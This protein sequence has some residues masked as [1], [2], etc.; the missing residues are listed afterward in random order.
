MTNSQSKPTAAKVAER[1]ESQ[2]KSHPPPVGFTKLA[3]AA[4]KKESSDYR[5]FQMYLDKKNDKGGKTTQSV[6]I[7]EDGDPETWCDWCRHMED[8]FAFMKVKEDDT[9]KKIQLITS[10]LRGKALDSFRTYQAAQEEANNSRKEPWDED[11]VLDHI[12]NDMALEIFTNKHSYCHQVFF[13]KYAI[14]MGD[15]TTVRAFE[16][17]ITWLNQCHKYFPMV[18]M[19]NGQ[20]KKCTPLDEDELCDIYT[21]AIKPA[22]ATKIMESNLE[23]NDLSL[24]E[25]IEYLEKLEQVDKMKKS[26]D[27]S[28]GKPYE[29]KRKQSKEIRGNARK[30]Q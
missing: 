23:P 13:M 9:D 12:L 2:V 29:G 5:E 19:R 7:F 16:K 6:P 24:A 14:F 10:I 26:V 21:L 25:L 17:R 3:K 18:K 11:D 30:K 15:G 20:Y 8:L 1:I 28:K 4:A 27:T 22:W